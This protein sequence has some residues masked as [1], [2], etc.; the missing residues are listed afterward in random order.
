M[1]LTKGHAC[2]SLIDDWL[3]LSFV[4]DLWHPQAKTQ[5]FFSQPKNEIILIS[6]L[7]VAYMHQCITADNS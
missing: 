3:L 6:E 7:I 2:L 5:H 1:R 4:D